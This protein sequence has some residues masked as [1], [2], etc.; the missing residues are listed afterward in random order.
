MLQLAI[1]S[2]REMGKGTRFLIYKWFP[3]NFF[4]LLF[5]RNIMLRSWTD[6][7]FSKLR[8]IGYLELD[9]YIA[10]MLIY[11][12]MV[13]LGFASCTNKK[14]TTTGCGYIGPEF[15]VSVQF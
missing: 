8:T 5:I 15:G 11:A 14:K 1:F 12:I 6:T 7:I 3:W 10:G 13:S 4:V 2:K 9:R